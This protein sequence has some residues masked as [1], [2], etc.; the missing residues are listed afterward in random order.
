MAFGSGR[1]L[2]GDFFENEVVVLE[3]GCVEEITTGGALVLAE[4]F[5][6]SERDECLNGGGESFL[7]VRICEDFDRV[8]ERSGSAQRSFS[9]RSVRMQ[10]AFNQ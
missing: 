10:R 7:I 3:F 1:F 9:E 8:S 2:G 6:L 5:G 4:A